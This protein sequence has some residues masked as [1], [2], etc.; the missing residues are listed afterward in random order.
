[1]QNRIDDNTGLDS[2]ILKLVH[3]GVALSEVLDKL[4]RMTTIA[5]C[6]K[7]EALDLLEMYYLSK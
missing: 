1:M 3:K 6:T 5:G 7:D 2:R 4:D